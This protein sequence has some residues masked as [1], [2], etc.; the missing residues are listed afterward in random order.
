MRLFVLAL[1]LI[2]HATP[3]GAEVLLRDDF[4]TGK[5]DASKWTIGTRVLGRTQ[6]G[7]VPVV[8]RGVARLRLDTHNAGATALFRGSE[9]RSR[10][11]FTRGAGLEL[12]ARVRIHAMPAG[13]VTSFFTYGS[14]KLDGRSVADEIDFECLSKH[15][16]TAAGTRVDLN[17][18]ND[19]D[20]RRG[21]AH[22]GVHNASAQP[23]VARL[24]LDVFHTFTIRWLPERTEWL[25]D[26]KRVWTTTAAQADDPMTVRLNFWA[27]ASSW[28]SAYDAGLQPAALA[29]Q[30]RS[31][32]YDVDRV[33]VRT[34]A[35][36]V[37]RQAGAAAHGLTD[38]RAAVAK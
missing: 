13:L 8:S 17:T 16:A 30:N 7:N 18:W 27:P 36:A 9:I 23:L 38:A 6:L 4:S 20:E 29:A 1:V 32:E 10:Q 35:R 25:I 15:I 21:I 26:G 34:A 5:L 28:S 11:I 2:A 3:A 33:V 19:W 12:E 31:F 24:E 14:H 37:R 22:D